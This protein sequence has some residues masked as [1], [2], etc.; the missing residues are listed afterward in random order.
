MLYPLTFEPLLKERPWGGRQ[1]ERLYGKP[2]PPETA[3][4]ESWEIADR[5]EG[6]SVIANGP[7]AGKDLRWLLEHHGPEVM[8]SATAI[9]GRFPLLVK[10]LDC[11]ESLS[12][13]VHPGPE[14]CAR[15]GGEPKSEV[16][17]IAAAAAGAHL[18]AGIRAGV[19]RGQFERKLGDGTVVDCLHKVPVRDGEAMYVPSGRVHSIGGGTV[20]FEIQQNSDTT[21]RVFDWDRKGTDGRPRELHI[22]QAMA[23][24]DF[25]D[26]EPSLVPGA[27][28]TQEGGQTRTLVDGPLFATHEWRVPAGHRRA[29]GALDRPWIVGVVGGRVTVRHPTSGVSTSVAPGQFCLVP[30]ALLDVTVEAEGAATYLLAAP[31]VAAQ[32]E[33]AEVEGEEEGRGAVPAW[34]AYQSHQRVRSEDGPRGLVPSRRRLKKEITKRLTYWPFLKILILNFWFRTA[35]L[36]LVSLGVVAGI[37]LPKVWRTSPPD[38]MPAIKVSVLDRIQARMLW[39]SAKKAEAA[40]NQE[41]A[42]A[43][44][45]EAF[46]NNR[47]DARLAR[48]LVG[49]ATQSDAQTPENLRGAVQTAEWLLR[50]T[51][52]NQTD[53]ETCV[54]FYDK[55]GLHDMTYAHLAPV[56][57]RMPPALEIPYTKALFFAG[58]TEAFDRRWQRLSASQRTNAEVA[59]LRAA[60]LAMWGPAETAGEG[61][62]ALAKAAEAKGA[63]GGQHVPFALRL[64]LAVCTYRG[65]AVGYG[66]ALDRLA[67][68]HQDTAGD[69][70]IHWRLLAVTGRRDEAIRLAKDYVFPPRSASDLARLSRT[71]ALLGMND[72]A[73]KTF[74]RYARTL[75]YT[76]DVW[77]TYADV[78]VDAQEWEKL[79]G[80]ALQMRAMPRFRKTLDALS[81]YYEGRADLGSGRTNAASTAFEQAATAN[82]VDLTQAYDTAKSLLALG[83]PQHA[84][85][86]IEKIEMPDGTD[87]TNRM[88]VLNLEFEVGMALQD[89]AVIV[90]AARAAHALD[91]RNIILSH[92]YA[93]ALLIE[94]KNPDEAIRFTRDL[95]DQFPSS[96]AA[97]LN[98]AYAL[99][100]SR[101]PDEAEGQ[102]KAL[103]PASLGA[104]HINT[105]Y[106]ALFELRVQR[107]Q[108]PAAWEAFDRINMTELFP[109][110]RARLKAISDKLPPRT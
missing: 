34:Q 64:L 81:R 92:R 88:R 99:L 31:A 41:H 3:I 77:L 66:E 93:A 89:E 20:V 23:A 110:E 14:L 54:R 27:F 57:D 76:E 51:R 73:L 87:R 24:I 9:E 7:L 8:G 60:Y 33:A 58:K 102:L 86:L 61:L 104:T 2:L 4:G 70:A 80:V 43:A 55:V 49:C 48:G 40:G 96:R 65:D 94:G 59:L 106:Q 91:P 100:L 15:M 37:L 98:H 101:R 85:T 1:L 13:Q 45:R 83:Y 32:A 78:L 22:A 67:D 84:K 6:V 97:L 72:E 46:A 62:E 82:F 74:D 19:K 90:R 109:C 38:F 12:V 44:W 26:F 79:R 35:V 36:V 95:R 11:Q 103:D 29:L 69:H 28:A 50:L 30:A 63:K 71:Y 68:L 47:G 56:E 53:L 5:P 39:R 108:Y 107:E 16:W 75:G 42:M 10:V 18:L 52:T 105:Y 25:D 17:Y 21:Y